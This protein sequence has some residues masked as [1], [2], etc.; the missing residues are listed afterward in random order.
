M[1]GR[2]DVPNQKSLMKINAIRIGNDVFFGG[3]R[4]ERIERIRE[5]LKKWFFSTNIL[6]FV[7]GDLIDTV[8]PFCCVEGSHS[9]NEE[10]GVIGISNRL[11]IIF[12][13]H[14][15]TLV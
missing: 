14:S 8:R 2:F 7:L 1:P 10:F 12:Y 4:I 3:T 11:V 5:D 13:H 15:A 9:V 6:P